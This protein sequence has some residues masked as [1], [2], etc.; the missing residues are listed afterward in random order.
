M[1]AKL[2]GAADYC[3][4]R[5]YSL[6]PNYPFLTM[7]GD[8]MTLV[9]NQLSEVGEHPVAL[10]VTLTDYPMVPPI[11]L[12]FMAVV[13][14]NVISITVE[15][16]PVNHTDYTIG[17]DAPVKLPFKMTEDPVCGLEFLIEP[18]KSFIKI[19][20][21]DASSGELELYSTNLLNAGLHR[22]ELVG[23]PYWK[24]VPKRVVFWVNMIDP[25]LDA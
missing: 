6:S 4:G 9:S 7:V 13:E 18:W 2:A 20:M 24:G 12:P 11:V 8:T 25:C 17:M 19:N 16:Q 14:C 23:R 3:G 15:Q 5:V 10:T 1:K 22:I 21:A